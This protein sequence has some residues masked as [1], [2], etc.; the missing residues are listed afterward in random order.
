MMDDEVGRLADE[1]ARLSMRLAETT[2]LLS[3]AVGY[4]WLDV[5]AETYH[6]AG[7]AIDERVQ[8]QARTNRLIQRGVPLE[9][10]K[11]S[12]QVV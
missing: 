7:R 6:A 2:T 10:A 3:I 9:A 11:M 12:L 1:T 4:A 5:W 8:R